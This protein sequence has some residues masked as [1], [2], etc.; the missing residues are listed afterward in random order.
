MTLQL[1]PDR[2][3]HGSAVDA[4]QESDVQLRREA[5]GVLLDNWRGAWT[6]PSGGLY[7]HQWSWDSALICIGLVH[8]SER[9]A[10][11]EL[12]SLLGAQWADGRVPQIVFDPA[13]PEG[14]Y[15][16]GPAFWRSTDVAGSAPVPTS[17]I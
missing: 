6:V 8:V 7:P 9:R 2:T 12:S 16:P 3:G 15:F 4:V 1:L 10:R 5:V 11:L 17:G 13:V 14:A